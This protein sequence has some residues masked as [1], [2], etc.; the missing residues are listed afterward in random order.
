[1]DDIP[2]DTVKK[3]NILVDDDEDDIE[4][5]NNQQNISNKINNNVSNPQNINL[6]IKEQDKEFQLIEINYLSQMFF[7]NLAINIIILL[8]FIIL[9]ILEYIYRRDLFNYSL[10]YEQNLQ[11]SLTKNG[12]LFFKLISL[13]GGYVLIGL[14]LFYFLVIF[15]SFQYL[16][17]YF[18]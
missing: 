4:K 17:F 2:Q 13:I 5:N 7:E 18:H 10:T 9:I 11:N 16:F 1:M 14:G 15:V 8:I 6:N 3:S 12:I